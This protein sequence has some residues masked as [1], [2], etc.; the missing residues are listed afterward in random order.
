MNA[1]PPGPTQPLDQSYYPL[2]DADDRRGWRRYIYGKRNGD[3]NKKVQDRDSLSKAK[4]EALKELGSDMELDDD[5]TGTTPTV[6]RH[7]D[8]VVYADAD[9]G[10]LVDDGTAG[11]EFTSVAF[12]SVPDDRDD[13]DEEGDDEGDSAQHKLPTVALMKMLDQVREAPFFTFLSSCLR[14]PTKHSGDQDTALT[15]LG[16]YDT[17]LSKSLSH[18]SDAPSST[19]STALQPKTPTFITSTD[20]HWILSLLASLDELLTGSDI[21]NLRSLARTCLGI[22]RA[23]GSRVDAEDQEGTCWMVVAAVAGVWKQSDLWDDA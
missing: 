18:H 10:Q 15:V 9:E 6:D 23:L 21:S 12:A 11:Q 17:W 13:L 16:H 8:T 7:D 19:S 3:K 14:A 2:P 20:R 22:L 4:Q 5:G 1:A